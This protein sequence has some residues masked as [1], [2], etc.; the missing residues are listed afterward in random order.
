MSSPE[1]AFDLIEGYFRVVPPDLKDQHS[2]GRICWA[3]SL[4]LVEVLTTLR[5]EYAKPGDE[6]NVLLKLIPAGQNP[7]LFNHPPVLHPP[8]HTDEEFIPVKTKRRPVIIVSRTHSDIPRALRRGA[9]FPPSFLIAPLYTLGEERYHPEFVERIKAF[10]YH[11][12]FYLPQNDEHGIREAFVRF[13]R[14]QSV[15]RRNLELTD[16]MLTQ[17]ALDVLHDWLTYH[18]TGNLDDT[19]REYR[20]LRLKAIHATGADH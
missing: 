6:T 7:N 11:Q 20:E 4:Y 17:N 15:A 18:T 1:S 8:I 14:I 5:V 2:P 16:T 10:E 13:D 3:P 9:D 19:I 12:F